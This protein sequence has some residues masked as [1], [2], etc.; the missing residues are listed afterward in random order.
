MQNPTQT[1]VTLVRHGETIWNRSQRMQGSQD[2]PL[3]DVGLAQAEAVAK[4]LQHE[5]CNIVY[6]SALSRAHQTAERIAEAVGVEHRVHDDL[7]E[8]TFG[9]FEGLTRD[10]ILARNPNFWDPG[11]RYDIPGFETF[12]RLVDRVTQTMTE[13]TDRHAG[14]HV[15]V[16]SHGGTIG[17]FLHAISGGS[18]GSGVHKLGNTSVT[19]VIREV[20]GSWQIVEVGCTAH[21]PEED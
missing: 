14:E 18:S 10:E 7:R 1:Y 16:V 9:E 12:E 19:R 6:S 17:A 2:I 20:D 15:L 4:R 3:T 13:I 5:P 11:V 21:L 8:R